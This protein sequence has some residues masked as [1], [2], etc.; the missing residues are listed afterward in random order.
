LAGRWIR[1]SNQPATQSIEC[2]VAFN[3]SQLGIEQNY[4]SRLAACSIRLGVRLNP[5]LYRFETHD[6]FLD[7][8]A[9]HIEIALMAILV[10]VMPFSTSA[11]GCEGFFVWRQF[12]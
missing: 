4:L 12:W 11:R 8:F 2:G 1:V 9:V 6:R 10:V 5:E 7:R 3:M